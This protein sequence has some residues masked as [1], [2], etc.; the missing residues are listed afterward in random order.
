MVRGELTP[1]GRPLDAETAIRALDRI[2]ADEQLTAQLDQL[3]ETGVRNTFLEYYN[4]ETGRSSGG[5]RD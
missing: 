3:D 4:R 2:A 5:D 1:R